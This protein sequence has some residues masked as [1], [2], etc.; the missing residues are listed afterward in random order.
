MGRALAIGSSIIAIILALP[1]L[2]AS[3][4]R[5][6]R[7]GE[8]FGGA[9]AAVSECRVLNGLYDTGKWKLAN[10][11]DDADRDVEVCELI[12]NA[13]EDPGAIIAE[14]PAGQPRMLGHSVVMPESISHVATKAAEDTEVLKRQ[15]RALEA[16]ELAHGGHRPEK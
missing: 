12:D 4:E 13:V 7:G 6:P 5:I 15:R 8:A 9:K 11:L 3:H 14:A 10:K 2:V 16:S 1:L